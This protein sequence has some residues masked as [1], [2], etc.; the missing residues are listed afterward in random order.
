[1]ET[2][3]TQTA[4]LPS[5][6]ALQENASTDVLIIGG[7]MAGMLCAHFLKGAGVDCMVVE[8]S[9]IGSGTT[10]GTTAVLSAQHGTLYT[11]LIKKFDEETAKRYLFA[12]LLAV[13]QF[14]ELAKRIDCD[15]EDK[16]SVMYSLDDK[17]ALAREAETVNRLGFPA[18]YVT[19]TELPLKVVSAVR[20]PNMAEF[21][22]LKFLGGLAEGLRIFEHTFVRRLRG[23]EAET[24]R[25]SVRAKRIIVASHYPFIN[26]RG[27]YF[28]KMYQKRSFVV[29]L[30]DM[31]ALGA[32]YVENKEDGIYLRSYGNRLIV[33]GGDSR[34]GTRSGFPKVYEFVQRY[35][36][37]A[38][39]KLSWAAQDCISLDGVPYI[40]AYSPN[41]PDLYVATGFN[42]WGMTSSM[43]AAQLLTDR[44]TGKENRFASVFSP[45]RSMMRGQLLQ[46]LA[47]TL[48]NFVLPTV[49]R[50]SHLGCS[51]KWNTF[52]QTWDCPCH[53]SR[54]DQHGK[55]IDNPA[56]RGIRARPRA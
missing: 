26:S 54:F 56:M 28:V 33:G 34:T 48:G 7:G 23:H 18:E 15:F 43:I 11:E 3:W 9:T 55:L 53:G 52:E 29:S 2:I 1:M 38:Q 27:L 10:K 22:P 5:F 17:D 14:R 36:P 44:L 24:D 31:P 41:T 40:G 19:H 20:Y 21:H 46:N 35:Y 30:E 6:P 45:Q 13:E 39:A 42:E 4:Q 32:T 16:P 37:K 50:C 47:V 12:N 8:A 25:G 51:L 49:P